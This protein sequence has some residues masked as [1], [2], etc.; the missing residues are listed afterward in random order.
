[1]G[2]DFI[3]VK[4]ALGKGSTFLATINIQS[5]VGSNFIA[6]PGTKL[7]VNS[8][9]QNAAGILSGMKI[10]LV[11]DSPDNQQLIQIILSRVGASVDIASDGI[12]GV[13]KAMSNNYDVILMDIQMPRMDGLEAIGVLR[14]QKYTKPVIALTAH[15]MK[16]HKDQ[17]LTAGF[18]DYL[19]KPIQRQPMMEML[20]KFKPNRDKIK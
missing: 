8:N 4:S 11:E 17:A 13:G 7:G 16:E 12:E 9:N 15:A 6:G 5:L 18:T 14:A 19:T 2:G 1:M 20:E 10:L 3:L